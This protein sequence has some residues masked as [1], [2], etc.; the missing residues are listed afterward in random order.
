M[1]EG[2][3]NRNAKVMLFRKRDADSNSDS[4]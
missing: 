1:R 2:N 4:A 3:E